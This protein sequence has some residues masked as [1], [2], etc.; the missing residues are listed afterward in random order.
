MKK[1][2]FESLHPNKK[3]DVLFEELVKL[4]QEV[5]VPW[6]KSLLS[7][8]SNNF[9]ILLIL[10]LIL[11]GGMALYSLVNSVNKSVQEVSEQYESTQN[12]FKNAIGKFDV[13]SLLKTFK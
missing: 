2:E 9:L 7:W 13:S 5:H 8:I 11:W 10:F 3:L 1:N 6:W 12:S 4:K